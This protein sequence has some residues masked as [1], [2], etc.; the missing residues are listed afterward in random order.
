MEMTT[1][2]RTS[3]GG[4]TVSASESAL[5]SLGRMTVSCAGEVNPGVEGVEEA[6]GASEEGKERRE[7]QQR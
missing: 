2:E 5:L 4:Q 3:E 6:R 1:A 7:D